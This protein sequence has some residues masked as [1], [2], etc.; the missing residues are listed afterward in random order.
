M[1]VSVC[2]CVT[3]CVCGWLAGRKGVGGDGRLIHGTTF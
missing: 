2:V 3:V 1:L